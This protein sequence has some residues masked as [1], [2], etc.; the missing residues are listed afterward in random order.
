MMWAVLAYLKGLVYTWWYG[1][2]AASGSAA[3]DDAPEPA[4]AAE[5]EAD[6]MGVF[7]SKERKEV[8]HII[9]EFIID[10]LK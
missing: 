2:A 3:G 7:T 9:R 5:E 10:E 4:A 6:P 8:S 1:S